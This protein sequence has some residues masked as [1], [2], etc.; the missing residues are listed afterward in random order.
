MASPTCKPNF[1]PWTVILGGLY[2]SARSTANLYSVIVISVSPSN[3]VWLFAA[4]PLA[5]FS[6][7]SSLSVSIRFLFLSVFSPASSGAI[8]FSPFTSSS[9]GSSFSSGMAT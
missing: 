9:A 7:G 3:V 6:S 2:I 4:S 8:S 1:S 5:L